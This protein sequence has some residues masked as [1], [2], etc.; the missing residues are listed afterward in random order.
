MVIDV[1]GMNLKGWKEGWTGADETDGKR[2]PTP[3]EIL[4]C[5]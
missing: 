1:D 3:P 4:E 2:P 5:E